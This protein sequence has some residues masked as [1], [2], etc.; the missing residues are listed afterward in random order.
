METGAYSR[1]WANA[2]AD[3]YSHLNYFEPTGNGLK[4]NVPGAAL[5]AA[6][7]E[8]KIPEVWGAFERNRGRAYCI[9][10]SAL[11][12]YENLLIGLDLMR[13]GDT[14]TSVPFEVPKDFRIGAGFWGA[15]RGFL[16]HH[17]VL[18][19]GVIENYQIVTPSTW[20]ASPKD[21]FGNPGPYEEAVA[22]TPLLEN[23]ERPE[24]FKGIDVLRAI[25]SFDPC[26]PCTTHIHTD[27]RVISREVI[28]CACGVDDDGHDH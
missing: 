13:K 16:T 17:C 10:Y 6:E 3:D 4:F 9:L 26:M 11:I 20:M 1:I 12:A 25:R 14:K 5:P 18:D 15:G 24:D 27:T 23:Y 19:K 7:L 21:P 2:L 22:A 28:T 8:W